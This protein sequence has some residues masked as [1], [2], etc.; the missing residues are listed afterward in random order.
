MSRSLNLDQALD[1]ACTQ[2]WPQPESSSKEDG[3]KLAMV[4]VSS[5][6]AEQY[7]QVRYSC[8]SK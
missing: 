3:P 1:H 7:E 2:A 5:S 8:T 6:Y 4:F